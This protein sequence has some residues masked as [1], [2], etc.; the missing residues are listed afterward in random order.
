M[1]DGKVLIV[2]GSEADAYN[3]ENSG[4][5]YRGAVWDP[6]G[7]DQ[8]SISVRTLEYDVFCSGTTVLPDGRAFV[9]GGTSSYVYTGDSRASVYDPATGAFSQSQSMAYGRWYGTATLLGDG[10]VMAI[11]GLDADGDT[12]TTVELY[13]PSDPGAGWSAP[14]SEPFWPPLYP[15]QFLLPNGKVFFTGHG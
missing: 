11:S 12:N 1:R 10:R 3:H 4:E 5:T 7:I 14:I 8:S 15:R 6:A 13:D 9:I 2:A